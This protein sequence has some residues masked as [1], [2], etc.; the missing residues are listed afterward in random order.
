MRLLARRF[1]SSI[2]SCASG[3]RLRA[4]SRSFARRL[5]LLLR[6][7]VRRRA[8]YRPA[9]ARD[10]V[11]KLLIALEHQRARFVAL[12]DR[13]LGFRL[14]LSHARVRAT[15]QIFH[16]LVRVR[17]QVPRLFEFFRE[18]LELY[19]LFVDDR[20]RLVALS[21]ERLELLL[22]LL[23]RRRAR[24]RPARA[25]D[26]VLELLLLL[27]DHPARFIALLG[28]LLELRLLRAVLRGDA[29]ELPARARDFLLELLI[30]L[31]HQ[32][33][34][35]V[36]LR[37]DLPE[38]LV[39]R[40]DDVPR[41]VALLLRGDDVRLDL[42]H[43]FIR[44]AFQV[45]NRRALV[46]PRDFLHRQP[47]GL[48][49]RV[50]LVHDVPRFVAL[51]EKSLELLVLLVHGRA[52]LVALAQK[53]VELL[54]RLFI[55]R[56]ARDGFAR[57]GE[58]LLQLLIPLVHQRARVVPLRDRLRERRLA[59]VRDV[60]RVVAFLDRGLEPRL[61][62]VRDVP[63]VVAF[64]GELIGG[65]GRGVGFASR[66]LDRDRRA[67]ELFVAR[68]HD[69]SRVVPL[70]DRL[71]ERRLALVRD[72]SRV[73]AFLQQ[74]VRRG[75]ALAQPA[76]RVLSGGFRRLERV[77]ARE[78]EVP[79]VVAF[80]DRRRQL[81]VARDDDR[82]RLVALLDGHL[83]VRVELPHLRVRAAFQIFDG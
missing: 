24:D 49:L 57:A 18:G 82:P 17:V 56:R 15:F 25:R 32:R 7:L 43:A 28:R 50:A 69:A 26:R 4:S 35:F 61:A 55:R 16:R 30:A 19:V 71:L 62:L 83:E 1:K 45:L 8:G 58:L 21:L 81:L 29:R 73:V 63:R 64:A 3:C 22:R 36:P 41:F 20:A 31:V 68:E 11:L 5:E 47:R 2:A 79:R 60:P 40:E 77:V 14:D 9:R 34:S 38:L 37:G 46:A 10:L 23:V 65:A 33:A 48:E 67:S 72:V 52:R 78:D 70:R 6:L 42:R 27:F 59:L 66:V 13:D 75:V 74:R 39:A 80:S 76:R 53:R 54:L 51:E 12:F 44:A